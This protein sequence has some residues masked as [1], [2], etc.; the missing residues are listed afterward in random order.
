[1]K[2]LLVICFLALPFLPFAQRGHTVKLKN[3][4]ELRGRLMNADSGQTWIQTRDGSVWVFDNEKVAGIDKFTPKVSGKGVFFRAEAGIVGGTQVSPSVLIT[5]GYSFNHHWDLGLAMGYER[6]WWE[7]YVPFLVNA[8]YNLL[9]NYFTPYVD[10][11]AGYEM[12]VGNWDN[13]KGG[14][15]AGARIGFTRYV[16]NRFG[17]TTSLGYR[18][19]YLKEE[20]PWWDDN[21]T[22]RQI[23]RF[24]VKFGFMF[25]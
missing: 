18:F 22:I 25:K 3:G 16:T 14:F 13:N 2:H 10:V 20:N 1:M 7:G 19:A 9:N 24:E 15:S 23:N 6:Y 21:I 8:R 12:P 11:L 5:N 4:T 17:F